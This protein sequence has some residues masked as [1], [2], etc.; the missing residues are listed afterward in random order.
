MDEKNKSAKRAYTNP[1]RPSQ[2]A[3]VSG[4]NGVIELAK[5]HPE[6]VWEAFHRW[7]GG[8]TRF[9]RPLPDWIIEKIEGEEVHIH[10]WDFG[11]EGIANYIRKYCERK[12]LEFSSEISDDSFHRGY[13]YICI[14]KDGKSVLRLHNTICSTRMNPYVCVHLQVEDIALKTLLDLFDDHIEL[15]DVVAYRKYYKGEHDNRFGIKD[16]G[17]L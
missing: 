4:I 8:Y 15:K 16:G 7:Y 5:K 13:T 6:I 17:G 12:K 9:R 2:R 1:K 14:S 10:L 3:T 11:V